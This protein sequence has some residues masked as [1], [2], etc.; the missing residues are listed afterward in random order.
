VGLV[1]CAMNRPQPTR[2]VVVLEGVKAKELTGELTSM[3][4][5]RYDVVSDKDYRKAAR[6]MHARRV[7]VTN[8]KK[9]AGKIGADAVIVG[10]MDRRGHGRYRLYLQLRSGVTGKMAKSWKVHLRTASLGGDR[11]KLD[12]VYARIDDLP[13][14][15]PAAAP[16]P[17]QTEAV[18]VAKKDKPL[19]PPKQE[20][21]AARK[22]DKA[23][24]KKDDKPAARKDDKPATKKNDKVVAKKDAKKKDP[25]A[26]DDDD[27][28]MVM[29]IKTDENGQVL[30]D[31]TPPGM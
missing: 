30:D 8:V 12:G 2:V 11:D 24:A 29:D 6:T 21:P 1:G 28:D 23:V 16:P 13:R 10:Q 25:D 17:K 26:D 22:D 20:E 15:E 4:G 14:L 9:I 31:E 3:L 5:D 7:S 27:D 19:P 18:A